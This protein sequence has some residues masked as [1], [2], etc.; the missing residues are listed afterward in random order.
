MAIAADELHTPVWPRQ[1]GLHVQGVIE[2]NRRRI[3]GAGS[4][5]GELGMVARKTCN[6]REI[7]RR[8]V[9]RFEIGVASRAIRVADF[10]EANRAAMIGVAACAGWRE[11]LR[12]LMNRAVMAIEASMIG[13]FAAE[14]NAGDHDVA[15]AAAI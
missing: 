6:M 2:S 1:I 9:A 3:G 12:R 13:N 7:V 15:R 14:E 4:Q 8:S 5:R 11:H 10:G